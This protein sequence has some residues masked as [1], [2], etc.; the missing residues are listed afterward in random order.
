MADFYPIRKISINTPVEELNLLNR[1]T[2]M[3]QLGIEYLSVADGK[4]TGRMPVDT[5]TYQPSGILHG[6]ASLALAETLAGLG[7][8]LIVDLA[9]HHVR[10]IQV[11]ANHVGSAID[12]FVYGQAEIIHRGTMTHLWNVSIADAEGR[13]LSTC[14][15]TNMII[16]KE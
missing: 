1:N 6:G 3:A 16:A 8:S 4:V 12:G 9:T 5:R 11:S 2:L 10:G 15:V 7:S 13:I 14:R